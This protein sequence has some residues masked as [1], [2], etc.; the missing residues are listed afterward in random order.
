MNVSE[1]QIS[2]LVNQLI[3]T[4]SSDQNLIDESPLADWMSLPSLIERYPD[5]TESQMR[6]ILFHRAKNGFDKCVRKVGKKL[7]IS[8][9][10]F[11]D[12]ISNCP[13]V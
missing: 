13:S 2:I 11:N 3:G 9:T 8:I 7:Y 5:F 10:G 12:W 4:L 1:Q 6:T